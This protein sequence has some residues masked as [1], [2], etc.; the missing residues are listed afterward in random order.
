[1]VDG[2]KGGIVHDF[3]EG[4]KISTV[5]GTKIVSGGV[6]K[7][8]KIAGIRDE[9]GGREVAN[10]VGTKEGTVNSLKIIVCIILKRVAH[11]LQ[12]GK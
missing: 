11:F 5:W 2:E 10:G 4:D 8:D 9:E 6:T 7:G 1:M 3:R 12:V